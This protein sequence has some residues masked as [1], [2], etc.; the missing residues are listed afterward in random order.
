MDRG[1]WWATVHRVAKGQHNLATE[2]QQLKNDKPR[3][4]IILNNEKRPHG[5]QPTSLLHP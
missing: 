2:Q 4:N 1:A 5:L 3:A